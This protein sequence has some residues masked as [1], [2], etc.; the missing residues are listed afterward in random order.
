MGQR[1]GNDEKKNFLYRKVKRVW[2]RVSDKQIRFRYLRRI[3]V[4]RLGILMEKTIQ[5]ALKE[6]YEKGWQDA[7]KN[8]S[9]RDGSIDVAINAH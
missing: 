2:L 9:V 8:D 7:L 6:A 4:F 3:L 1:W 5:Y